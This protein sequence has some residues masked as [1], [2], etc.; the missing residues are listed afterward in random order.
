MW[1]V[2]SSADSAYFIPPEASPLDPLEP[3][4]RRECM[5]P[6]RTRS[7]ESL[8]RR[9]RQRRRRHLRHREMTGSQRRCP[10][11]AEARDHSHQHHPGGVAQHQ[12]RRLCTRGAE[13]HTNS[14]LAPAQGHRVGKDAV[15]SDRRK[16]ERGDSKPG[17]Q[18]QRQAPLAQRFRDRLFHGLKRHP[19]LRILRETRS[20]GQVSQRKEQSAG[21]PGKC[22]RSPDSFLASSLRR[23]LCVS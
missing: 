6:E 11:T 23:L 18:P 5:W 7:R 13:S 15:N 1:Y 20:T 19:P 2:E 3:L 10:G 14:D 16:N 17:N 21:S 9:P 22:C 4:S 8:R 12:A